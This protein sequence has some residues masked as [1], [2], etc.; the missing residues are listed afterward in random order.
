LSGYQ[1]V[2]ASLSDM[3]KTKECLAAANKVLQLEIPVG[4]RKISFVQKH[5][6]YIE[7]K[8]EDLAGKK[9]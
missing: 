5:L 7:E 1:I 6:R 3:G 9:N 2:V 8:K 4:A